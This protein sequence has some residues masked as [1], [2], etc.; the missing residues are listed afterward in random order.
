[1]SRD[2]PHKCLWGCTNREHIVAVGSVFRNHNK[3]PYQIVEGRSEILEKI[4]DD[5]WNPFG[6][7]GVGNNLSD[8]FVRRTFSLSHQF[9][10][11]RS[12]IPV[13]LDM[14]LVEVLLR[15]VELALNRIG[16]RHSPTVAEGAASSE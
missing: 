14:E 6:N 9:G 3:L 4:A 15:P 8:V 10:W 1:M 12:E 11:I 2:L 13:R 7:R 16:K 5:E